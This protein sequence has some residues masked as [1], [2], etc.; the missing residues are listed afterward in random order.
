MNIGDRPGQVF[1]HTADTSKI[2]RILGW[3][4]KISFESGLDKTIEW[5][6]ENGDWWK[7]KLWMRHVPI[8]T[9][10]GKI[11]MH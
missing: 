8:E 6:L 7:D 3:K 11:E 9:R 5:Y 2:R 4:P 1:R 10:K